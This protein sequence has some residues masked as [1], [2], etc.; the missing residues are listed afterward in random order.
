MNWVEYCLMVWL[1]KSSGNHSLG[2]RG[3]W[4]NQ[5]WKR[6]LRFLRQESWQEKNKKNKKVTAAAA[7]LAGPNHLER[8]FSF[9]S[10][11]KKKV[12]K[13][14]KLFWT[15]FATV[16]LIDAA[17][18][19][20]NLLFR[21]QFSWLVPF[22]SKPL[23]WQILSHSCRHTPDGWNTNPASRANV[24]SV[25]ALTH[26]S[27]LHP[28]VGAFV[29]RCAPEIY[30]DSDSSSTPLDFFRPHQLNLI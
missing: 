10:S 30:K 6:R 23:L 24:L 22:F 18:Q 28:A 27:S 15:D 25:C 13:K 21:L 4:V 7:S 12:E 17:T 14:E 16:W 29:I 20:F 5:Y 8:G 9:T 11:Q 19:S 2:V 1:T 3:A 26:C